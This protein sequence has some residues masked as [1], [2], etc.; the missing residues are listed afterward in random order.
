MTADIKKYDNAISFRQALD[1]RIKNIAR[2]RAIP[3]IRLRRQITFDRFLARLFDV[4]KKNQQW[5]L[6]GGYAL[7]FRFHN[8][9]RTT[10]DIDF[11]IPHM[12]NPDENAFRG[13]N[14]RVFLSS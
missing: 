11:T 13:E 10:K 4:K 7:E 12:K 8:L 5:L 3:L 14:T 6:K 2:Q 9:A 1:D